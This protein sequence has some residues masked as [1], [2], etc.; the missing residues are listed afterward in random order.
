MGDDARARTGDSA[1]VAPPA[2]AP[3]EEAPDHDHPLDHPTGPPEHIELE[4]DAHQ[5]SQIEPIPRASKPRAT[6]S[7]ASSPPAPP[8]ADKNAPETRRKVYATLLAVPGLNLSALARA[9]GVG[10]SLTRYHLGMLMRAELAREDKDVGHA[11]YYPVVSGPLGPTETVDRRDKALIAVLRRA[12]PL[13]MVLELQVRTHN[14][15]TMGDLARAAGVSPGTA[16]Y[17]IGKLRD[18]GAI[19]TIEEGRLRIVVLLEPERIK[20]LLAKFPPPRDLV[21]SFTDLWDQ[22]NE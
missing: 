5:E 20:R 10:E 11:R 4:L 1:S 21:Q 14:R 3:T 6:L 17:H 7:P 8:E 12:G 16:T 9:A 18:L 15:A 19:D 13:R 2:V 22:V